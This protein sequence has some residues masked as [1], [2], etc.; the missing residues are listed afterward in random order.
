M[1]GTLP[2]AEGPVKHIRPISGMMAVRS[3]WYV[4]RS[5]C[6]HSMAEGL[7]YSYRHRLAKDLSRVAFVG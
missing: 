4:L 2:S 1:Q 6:P 5:H 3:H 7:F